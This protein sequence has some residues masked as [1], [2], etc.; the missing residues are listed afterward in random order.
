VRIGSTGTG[1]HGLRLTSAEA[2]ADDPEAAG[3]AALADVRLHDDAI[4]S[5]WYREQTLPVL[6]RRVL[7]ELQEAA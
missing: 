3:R 5:A 2:K 4:A 7:T 6:V 1:S